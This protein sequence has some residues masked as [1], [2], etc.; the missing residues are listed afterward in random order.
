MN[1]KDINMDYFRNVYAAAAYLV[2]F[3]RCGWCPTHSLTNEGAQFRNLLVLA[4]KDLA[5]SQKSLPL[6]VE[7]LEEDH[8]R[9]TAAIANSLSSD[10]VISAHE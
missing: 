10:V 4:H 9:R 7:P 2:E 6:D 8:D 1:G 3:E 5:L